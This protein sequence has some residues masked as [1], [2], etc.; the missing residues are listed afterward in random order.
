MFKAFA[1]AAALSVTAV[2]AAQAVPVQYQNF[3]ALPSATFGGSGIPNDPAAWSQFTNSANG[4]VLTLGLIATQ[5]FF[6][7]P[8]TNDGAG[9]YTA[10]VGSNTGGPGSPSS[11]TGALWNFSY[12]A[13]LE[14]GVGSTLADYG[15]ELR[16]DF[17][18]AFNN[19]LG[20]LGTLTTGALPFLSTVNATGTVLQGSQ[21]L[22]FNF[23]S[24]PV[25]GFV[26]PPS[27]VSTFDPNAAGEY[28]FVLNSTLGA[29]SMNVNVVPLPVAAPMLISAFAVW[30]LMARRR[31][32][33][34]V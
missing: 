15:I 21:N 1:V 23:L 19:T 30:G 13:A 33:S 34:A 4:D 5:R 17:D 11:L 25:S 8:L 32:A 28:S 18:P 2:G 20:D 9:T 27:G 3:S 6:N 14:T 10:Q 22:L 12:Y 16:Y 29:V 7:P 24:Q 26:A 31:R